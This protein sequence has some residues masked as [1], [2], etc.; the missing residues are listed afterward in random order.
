MKIRSLHSWNL[1]YRDAADLQARLAPRIIRKGG[2]AR[3]RTVAGA[4]V[5][6]DKGSDLFF[7]VVLLLEAK[8][9]TVLEEERA[10]GKSPF[11]YI[12]G[13]L[14]F[15]EAPL[16]LRAF[17]KIRARPDLVLIDGQGI[18]HPRGFGLA[19][20]LG[21]LLDIPT[22]GC[23]KSV[24]VGE[25]DEPGI[26]AGDFSKMVYQRKVVGAALRTRRG[27]CPIYVSPGHKIGLTP[28]LR[29]VLSCGRGY[30][31]PEPTRLAHHAVNRYRLEQRGRGNR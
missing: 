29:H 13:L 6:Y 22:V 14:S 8:T 15:R 28:S 27:V 18:A 10:S 12:P 7:A 9:M 4:D 31:L 20:H 2:P 16:L 23:A 24:L 11:P 21:L 25:F 5:S 30:R 19:S 3:L 1:T 26:E 17:R